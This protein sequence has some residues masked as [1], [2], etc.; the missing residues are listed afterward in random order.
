MA[1]VRTR[2]LATTRREL[3]RTRRAWHDARQKSA[4]A[5]A[6]VNVAREMGEDLGRALLQKRQANSV[7]DAAD[8][9]LEEALNSYQDTAWTVN[10]RIDAVKYVQDRRSIR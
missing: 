1:R 7:R 9:A 5:D 4:L 2:E 8:L 10:Q 6:A 3:E